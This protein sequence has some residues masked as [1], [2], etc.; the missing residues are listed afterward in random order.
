R[1]SQRI[2]RA[3][4]L[5]VVHRAAAARAGSN[6]RGPRSGIQR[7]N[8]AEAAPPDQRRGGA[9]LRSRR[10]V[11]LE[12]ARA[13]TV[14]EEAGWMT[15]A[16]ARAGSTSALAPACR[17]GSTMSRSANPCGRALDLGETRYTADR[18]RPWRRARG[19]P[20]VVRSSRSG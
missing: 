1:A 19:L 8:P 13:G 4:G 17:F 16:V 9:R 12:L 18:T 7:R 11:R 20:S 15:Y 14:L 3:P 2:R 5:D 10:T 6:R